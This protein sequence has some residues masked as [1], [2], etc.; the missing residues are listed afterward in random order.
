MHVE[1]YEN[2]HEIEGDASRLRLDPAMAEWGLL[3]EPFTFVV[4]AGG[5]V[6]AKF[7]GFVTE[8]ELE[9][10]LTAVLDAR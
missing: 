6:A 3:T 9:A 1:V 4:D 7:E 5:R 10:A 2:A 8:G